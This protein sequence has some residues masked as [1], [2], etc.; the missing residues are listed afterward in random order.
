MLD[1]SLSGRRS[2]V[3][4]TAF[5]KAQQKR[6][7]GEARLA[8]PQPLEKRL[9]HSSKDTTTSHA[10]AHHALPSTHPP[11][12]HRGPPHHPHRVRPHRPLAPLH[13]RVGP[14]RWQPAR[15]RESALQLALQ[16]MVDAWIQ[17][18]AAGEWRVDAIGEIRN[19]NAG[20]RSWMGASGLTACASLVSPP[21]SSFLS[22]SDPLYRSIARS[23]LSRPSFALDFAPRCVSLVV[24]PTSSSRKFFPTV[25]P[26]SNRPQRHHRLSPYAFCYRLH[27][28]RRSPP[29]E[30]STARLA[31]TRRGRLGVRIQRSGMLLV[32]KRTS[33]ERVQRGREAGVLRELPS[34]EA[35]L[36]A[37]R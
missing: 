25:F 8:R 34:R 24:V 27:L 13:V 10:H 36:D 9:T 4:P 14:I 5:Q 30:H 2:E 3:Y 17:G 31:A 19:A 21:P 11:R 22:L 33:R 37:S 7:G 6:T 1:F 12:H 32:S 20:Q 18:Q 26:P 28:R 29:A 16:R 23:I 35:C 15:T